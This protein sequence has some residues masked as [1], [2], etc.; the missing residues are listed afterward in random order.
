[1]MTAIWAKRGRQ[2]L[3]ASLFL[4]S[5][6]LGTAPLPVFAQNAGQDVNLSLPQA[7]V[8]ARQAIQQGNLALADALSTAL[9]EAN[10]SDAEA[11]MIRAFVARATGNLD[12]AEDNAAAAYRNAPN[13]D[14]KFDAAM[15]TADI[16]SRQEKLSRA[17][18]WL[19]RAD[20]V[21]TTDQRKAL[22]ARSFRQ[23]AARNPLQ[24]QLRFTAKPSNNV[25]NGAPTDTIELGGLP[26]RLDPSGVQLGGYEA[27]TGISL[28]YRL[29]ENPTQKT[30]L[31]GE[32]FYRYI[33]LDSDAKE[34]APDVDGTDFN[35]GVV[36]TG[37]RHQRLV[38]PELGTT[39]VTG[40]VG[41]SWYGDDP[42]AR[43]FEV[44]L[45]QTVKQG[46][47]AQF[48]FGLSAR[49]E[50]RLDDRIND[51]ES[52]SASVDYRFAAEGGGVYGI[53]TTLKN[54]WSDSATVDL[55]SFA[56]R[57]SRSFDQIGMVQPS[58]NF[59]VENRNYHKWSST[60]GGR[61]D[62]SV[63]LGLTATFPDV[64]YYGFSPQLNVSARRTRS[65]VEIYDRNELSI[66]LTAVSRF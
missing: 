14:L 54:V 57:G 49:S 6:S 1:M 7:R 45:G 16:L 13:D 62:V 65:D 9:L 32:F 5:I 64:T 47:D 2:F 59:S 31:L 53:G 61:E 41:Q 24:V 50:N 44:Q 18:L 28:S 30:E 29:S 25:N 58:V 39:S 43:W 11:L 4:A 26:F 3:A 8:L 19:R 52:L 35:Y 66:G 60:A 37:L 42:L 17:Q 56:V 12:A 55:F 33:W 21:A 51:S 23:V 48:R 27:S 63:S 40:L 38:W 22:A 34:D 46:D 10:P 20:Q 15:L 36:I